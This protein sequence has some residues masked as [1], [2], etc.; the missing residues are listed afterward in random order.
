MLLI[1]R[2]LAAAT[3]CLLL[4]GCTGG[5]SFHPAA[6]TPRNPSAVGPGVTKDLRVGGDA[7]QPLTLHVD[8]D[9]FTGPGRVTTTASTT[10]P[11]AALGFT[12]VGSVQD[13]RVEGQLAHP[14]SLTFSA[15]A[16][17]DSLPAIWHGTPDGWELVAIGGPGAVATAEQQTFSPYVAGLIRPDIMFTPEPGQRMAAWLARWATGTTT[18]PRCAAEPR[19]TSLVGPEMDVLLAC[20]EGDARHAVLRVKN[21][22]GLAHQIT[23][24]DTVKDVQVTGQPDW[25]RALVRKIARNGNTVVL[26]SGE[27]MTVRLSR[28]DQDT[29]LTVQPRAVLLA[30]GAELVKQLGHLRTGVEGIIVASGVLEAAECAGIGSDALAGTAPASLDALLDGIRAFAK[31]GAKALGDDTKIGARDDAARRLV[32]ARHN[33]APD[34]VK[35]DPK[36]IGQVNQV[37]S[38]LK[39]IGEIF[40]AADLAKLAGSIWQAVDEELRLAIGKED[41]QRSVHLKLYK[42]SP[43]IGSLR[44][45][46]LAECQKRLFPEADSTCDPGDAEP[47][48]S[49]LNPLYGF[50][51]PGN[52]A[53]YS[54][55]V[56]QHTSTYSDDW[57]LAWARGGGADSCQ[58]ARQKSGIPLD[59]LRDLRVCYEDFRTAV[60]SATG[61][62]PLRI[63]MGIAKARGAS[64]DSVRDTGPLCPPA[65]PTLHRWAV[66]GMDDSEIY[67]LAR[68][69][70][71]AAVLLMTPGPRTP[72]GL[73]VGDPIS[74]ARRLYPT[75]RPDNATDGYYVK[76]GARVL[77]FRPAP[78]LDDSDDPAVEVITAGDPNLAMAYEFC[79]E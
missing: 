47:R 1:Q 52:G 76:S 3:A 40:K 63:G 28:P 13:I 41:D 26:P 61:F 59:V 79:S 43:P 74:K 18:P 58:G 11:P 72:E 25:V 20:V 6:A 36:Y 69:G 4:A 32:A 33:V 35:A 9:D 39:A 22:R 71:L 15:A 17:P 60:L 2:A 10:P 29:S 78:A 73:Q 48:I 49:H 57:R 50:S 66:E 21:N 62:G 37:G 44:Q 38:V 31:C 12:A 64:A 65:E 67:L 45:A 46:G 68:R 16:S 77:Y 23:L 51:G 56:F 5:G 30:M 8:A 19:W 53:G 70:F 7:Q 75:A 24:P 34:V 42:P 54:G 27:E 55:A 14:V